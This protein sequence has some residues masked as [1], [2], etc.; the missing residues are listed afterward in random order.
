MLLSKSSSAARFVPVV[1]ARVKAPVESAWRRFLAALLRSRDTRPD[2][3]DKN[4]CNE[5]QGGSRLGNAG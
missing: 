2:Q 1:Q 3:A 4:R 5:E